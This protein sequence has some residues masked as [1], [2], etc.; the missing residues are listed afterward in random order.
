M[1]K[2][3]LNFRTS[4]G[5]KSIVG[6]DLITDKF[7]AIFELVK[8]SYDAN[9]KN[10][11]VSFNNLEHQNKED[12]LDQDQTAS[13]YELGEY[14][15]HLIIRDDGKGMSKDDLQ[16]KWLFL[17]YSEKKD[18]EGTDNKGRSFVGSKGVGRFSC[19]TL[20]GRLILKTKKANENIEHQLFVNWNQF[21]E[22]QTI[23]FND[24]KVKY[25]SIEHKSSAQYTELI[26]RDLRHLDWQLNSE[27]EKTKKALEKLKNPFKKDE[28]FN[29]Y[30]GLNISIASPNITHKII[31]N[32]SEI[33]KDKTTTIEFKLHDKLELTLID[34]GEEIFR[35]TQ[36]NTTILKNTPLTIS[37]HF[38]NASA[39][40]T[41]TRHMKIQPV[42]YGTVF[43]Y[44]NSFRVMPYGDESIDLFGLNLRKTQ[45]YNRYIATRELLG[46]IEITDPNNFFKESSSRNSGFIQNSYFSTLNELY[47]DKVH[48]ILERYI[49]LIQWGENPDTAE[50]I[51]FDPKHSELDTF[52]KYLLS[53]KYEIQYFKDN[54]E[55]K[56][57]EKST[58]KQL[59][60]II[61]KTTDISIKSL[62]ANAKAH[63]K[64]L[65]EETKKQEKKISQ[66]SQEIKILQQ[67]N[68]NLSITREPKSYSEQITHH[69]KFMAENLYYSSE[70]LLELT[71]Q[72]SDP[73]LKSKFK[74]KISEI[75]QTQR[76][77]N[78]FRELLIKTNLDLRA[79]QKVDWYQQA[80]FFAK[81]KYNLPI[82]QVSVNKD[83]PEESNTNWNIICNVI[84][85][86]MMFENFYTNAKD[87]QATYL[88]IL[89]STTG[90][91]VISSNSE[92]IN[93]IHI[94]NIF[95]LGY[96]T[97]EYGTG[98]GLYQIK[99]FLK[100]LKYDIR[101]QHTN[102]NVQF[103]IDK[104]D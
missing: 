81:Q 54:L 6:R 41:F 26:I 10:V 49:H 58:E 95:Q 35:L 63:L 42:N 69:F 77:L 53:K 97:K 93:E 79:Q 28:G 88:D 89:F 71:S 3:T 33:I 12:L 40:N 86:Q 103:I 1:S 4:S 24:I 18:K 15:P 32:I 11:I 85:L 67:Q 70:D 102:N 30:C 34:R 14:E 47:M 78:I 56:I 2:D 22:N 73:E 13:L 23:E 94:N 65:K 83:V 91:L 60:K 17:A 52:K 50:E 20:G 104:Q 96:S 38:L 99:N 46:Y 57:Q 5:I 8:N 7:V 62:A 55:Q 74:H 76:E 9:A 48:R 45:G 72:I 27:Q 16:N 64:N 37:I 87:H 25:R 66:K 59:D 75:R 29:L 84:D 68:T 43:I 19:D 98:I 61:S 21:E 90:Q 100:S 31:N 44:K 101:V 92:P 36:K 82:L 39:K 80:L 51:F